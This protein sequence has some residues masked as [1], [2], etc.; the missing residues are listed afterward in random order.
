M[1]HR[2]FSYLSPLSD[3][4]LVTLSESQRTIIAMHG[5]FTDIRQA[6]YRKLQ[7]SRSP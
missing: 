1:P 7:H 4:E 3:V 6:V 2:D 5:R